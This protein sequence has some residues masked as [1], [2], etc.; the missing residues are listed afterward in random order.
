MNATLRDVVGEIKHLRDDRAPAFIAGMGSNGLS[1]LRSLGRRGIS[2]VALDSWKD[3]GMYSRYCQPA[4]VPDPEENESGLLDLLQEIGEA[5]PRRSVL[6]PT[7]DAFILFVSKHSRELANH[8]DFEV[9]DYQAVLTMANKRLQYEYAQSQGIETPLTRFPRDGDIEEI[10]EEM[11][12]PSVIKPYFSHLWRDYMGNRWGKVAEVHS[13]GELLDTYAEMEASG[14]EL[15]VQ[16]K[17]AGG[18][19]QLYGLLTYL[20]RSSEPRAIFTKRK[21]RQFPRNFGDGSIAVG[22]WEPEVAELGLKLLRGLKFRGGASVEFKRDSQDGRLKLMEVNPRSISS[23][24]HAVVSGVDIPFIAYQH[25]L[26][27]ETEKAE[28]FREGVKWIDFAKDFKS[29]VE[30]QRAGNLDLGRWF[31]SWRGERCF[32]FFAWDDPMPAVQ[33]FGSALWSTVKRG[34]ATSQ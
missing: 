22:A 19:D 6:I 24:S 16:E 31:R 34:G 13:A 20:D 15:M 3:P 4:V 5:V 1:Y 8:Y 18:D 27:N 14:L 9:A 23:T 29:L 11:D 2:V 32:A 21:L 10:A 28:T 17:I 30:L 12:Y 7:S 26:G 25:A 33:G